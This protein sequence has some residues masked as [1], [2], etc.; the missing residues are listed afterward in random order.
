MKSK[1]RQQSHMTTVRRMTASR[2]LRAPPPPL[3]LPLDRGALKHPAAAQVQQQVQGQGQGEGTLAV[4]IEGRI[5]RRGT[6]RPLK[7]QLISEHGVR[8]V[9]W[10]P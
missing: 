8:R 3:T 10:V 1:A 5:M 4:L 9:L 7:T 2:H 6:A